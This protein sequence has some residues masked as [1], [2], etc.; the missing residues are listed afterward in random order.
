MG[1]EGLAALV[2]PRPAPL[3]AKPEPTPEPAVIQ[4][5]PAKA[6]AS[7]ASLLIWVIAA[8]IGGVA[9]VGFYAANSRA[10]RPSTAARTEAPRPTVAPPPAR[11]PAPAVP[12]PPPVIAPPPAPQALQET[13]PPIGSGDVLGAPQ[14]VYCLAE[15][16]RLDAMK[17]AVNDRI[18]SH[19]TRFNGLIGD[20]NARCSNYRY[21]QSDM[22]LARRQVDA[23]RLQLQSDATAVVRGWR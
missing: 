8:T 7:G 1:F 3:A 2:S 18:Q 5:P 9:I 16:L 19:V 22:D 6:A 14:I 4:E 15:S 17:T 23:R 13:K 11:A 21:R 20:Y 10:A 12:T